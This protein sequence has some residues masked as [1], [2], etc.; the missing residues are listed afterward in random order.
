MPCW[1]NNWKWALLFVLPNPFWKLPC[2]K[3]QEW[4]GLCC[5]DCDIIPAWQ[6]IRENSFHA[7]YS[8]SCTHTRPTATQQLLLKLPIT[9]VHLKRSDKTQFLEFF[10]RF[11]TSTQYLFTN[12]ISITDKKIS[13]SFCVYYIVQ[14]VLTWIGLILFFM[15]PT[16][17]TVVTAAPCSEHMGSRQ[18]LA[19][20]C[21]WG[22]KENCAVK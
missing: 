21:L 5:G 2:Y 11:F 9:P 19:G 12:P 17:S 14:C 13:L 22:V 7:P 3:T 20:W 1:C 16:P 10:Q 15:L 8:I 6:Y 4:T 18:E